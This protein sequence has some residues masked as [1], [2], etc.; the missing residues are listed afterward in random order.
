[1]GFHHVVLVQH[2]RAIAVVAA[3]LSL[4]LV[5]AVILKASLRV[6]IL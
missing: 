2:S 5:E 3:G 1:M 6:A 4:Y